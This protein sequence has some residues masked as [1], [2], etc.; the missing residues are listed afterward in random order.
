MQTFMSDYFRKFYFGRLFLLILYFISDPNQDLITQ[1]DALH[2]ICTEYLFIAL[3]AINSQ[4]IIS[5]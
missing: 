2:F 4:Q 3:V 5:V 1:N